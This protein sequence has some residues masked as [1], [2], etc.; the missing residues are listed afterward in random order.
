MVAHG[1]GMFLSMTWLC[2]LYLTLGADSSLPLSCIL[3]LCKCLEILA[4]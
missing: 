4:Q 1:L 2:F 3:G